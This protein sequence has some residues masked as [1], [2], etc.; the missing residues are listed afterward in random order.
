[1]DVIYGILSISAIFLDVLYNKNIAT[2]SNIVHCAYIK[3][4]GT[5]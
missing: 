2:L 4:N 3:R 5:I 1:M